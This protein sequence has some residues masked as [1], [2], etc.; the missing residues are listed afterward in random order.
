VRV[1]A[2]PGDGGVEPGAVHRAIIGGANYTP[3]TARRRAMPRLP[4]K[5]RSSP[6]PASPSPRSRI[7]CAHARCRRLQWRHPDRR[8]SAARCRPWRDRTWPA[9]AAGAVP[10]LTD[11]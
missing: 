4:G 8:G 1:C 9:A 2:D 6:A 7:R 11:C 5:T 10:R 3:G